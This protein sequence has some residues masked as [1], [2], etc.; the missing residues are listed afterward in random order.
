MTTSLSCAAIGC[1]LFP[2]G[3]CCCCC[4]PSRGNFG[5]LGRC[6]LLLICS[7]VAVEQHRAPHLETRRGSPWPSLVE[8][9]NSTGAV[10][11]CPIAS[12]DSSI[13]TGI[14]WIDAFDAKPVAPI[15]GLRC[16]EFSQFFPFHSR[17]ITNIFI[18]KI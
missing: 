4:N 11:H 8:M 13:P 14:R 16:Y 12:D 3:I 1:K 2:S 10:L 6:C 5:P 18:L 15:A 9:T 17:Q 7:T